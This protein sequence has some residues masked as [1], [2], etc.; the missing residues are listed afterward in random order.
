MRFSRK[1]SPTTEFR[2]IGR[3][4]D[5]SRIISVLA[6]N[7][8]NMTER[9][10]TKKLANSMLQSRLEHFSKGGQHIP[11]RLSIAWNMRTRR[12]SKSEMKALEWAQQVD[13]S[14]IQARNMLSEAH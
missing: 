4:D 7:H 5:P 8:D 13:Q 12:F 2:G 1:S 11:A 3:Y 14:I 10:A 6:N 9:S